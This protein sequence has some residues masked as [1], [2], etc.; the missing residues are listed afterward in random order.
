MFVALELQW[1]NVK[2]SVDKS[3]AKVIDNEGRY[4][5]KPYVYMPRGTHEVQLFDDDS[6]R[7]ASASGGCF[8]EGSSRAGGR[9]PFPTFIKIRI[10]RGHYYM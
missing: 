3:L 10:R 9:G 8:C 6:N 7:L 1:D 5:F 2:Q 4:N